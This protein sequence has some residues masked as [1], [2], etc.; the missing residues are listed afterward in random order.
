METYKAALNRNLDRFRKDLASGKMTVDDV[1]YHTAKQVNDAYGHLNYADLGRS[2]NVQKLTRAIL[3]APDFLEAR[4]RQ[5]LHGAAGLIPGKL[6]RAHG[7][8]RMAFW[9]L[10]IGQY[11]LARSLNYLLDDKK[12]H[13]DLRDAFAVYHNGRRYTMRSVPGDVLEALTEFHKFAMARLA[14]LTGRAALEFA[15]G[16][17]YKGQKVTGHGATPRYC[18]LRDT[19]RA[20]ECGGATSWAVVNW[21]S[22]QIIDRR[23]CQF[24]W[25]KNQPR[26]AHH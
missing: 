6:A 12:L 19:D 7:E 20:A 8:Q 14:P 18:L 25:A 1:K 16:T 11:V 24:A 3:L 23:G 13:T 21:R 9:T 26:I 2:E 5:A 15:T 17:N 4:V 22:R 10:A